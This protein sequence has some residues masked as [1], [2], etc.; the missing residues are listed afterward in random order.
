[1]QK[2]K[3]KRLYL[4]RPINWKKLKVK[5]GRIKTETKVSKEKKNRRNEENQRKQ[6]VKKEKRENWEKKRENISRSN[7]TFKKL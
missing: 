5:N 6:R 2:K 1:M 4:K 7:K 3:K